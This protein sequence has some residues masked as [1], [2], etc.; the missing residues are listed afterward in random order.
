MRKNG[1]NILQ[2]L[3]DK[4][5]TLCIFILAEFFKK[6]ALITIKRKRLK[7]NGKD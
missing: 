3:I 7:K 1:D 4:K 2:K 6:N 5:I